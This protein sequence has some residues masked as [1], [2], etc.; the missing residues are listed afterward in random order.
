MDDFCTAPPLTTAYISSSLIVR[1]EDD[2]APTHLHKITVTQISMLLK[3]VMFCFFFPKRSIVIT[4]V[5]R[6]YFFREEPEG[7][8]GKSISSHSGSSST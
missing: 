6:E 1:I 3:N 2:V 4:H 5:T 8:G 7:E